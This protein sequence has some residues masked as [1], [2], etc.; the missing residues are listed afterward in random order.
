M[1]YLIAAYA[2]LWAISFGLVLSMHLRQRRLQLDLRVLRQLVEDA[3][4]SDE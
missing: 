1:G 3:A 2:V 4:S